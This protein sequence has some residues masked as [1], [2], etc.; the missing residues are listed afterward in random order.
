MNVEILIHGVPDGQ[1]Y[2]GIAEER[3]YAELFYD[4]SAESIKFVVEPK[5]TGNNAFVYYT[6]LRYKGIVGYGGRP[7]SYFGITLRIDKY[8]LDVVHVYNMLD[9][10]FKKHVIGVLLSPLGESYKYVVP[11]FA[12][13]KAE[14]DQ[15]QQGLA[16]LI[17]GTCVWS[18]FVDVDAN[19]IHPDAATASCNIADITENNMSAALKKYSKVILSP[20]YKLNLAKEYEKKIQEAEG[21]GGGMVAEKDKKIAE[22]DGVISSLNSTINSHQAKIETL[23]AEVKRKD[24]EILQIKTRNNLS[25]M[26]SG[27]KEPINS[28]AEYFNVHDSQKNPP[29]PSFGLKNFIIGVVSCVLSLIV[30][31]LLLF[32]KPQKGTVDTKPLENQIAEL[33]N[34]NSQ[35]AKEIELRDNTIADLRTQLAQK[36][37]VQQPSTP[38][39][40]STVV[41][42]KL[43][44]DIDPYKKNELL[45]C[46][47]TYTIK[48]Q[49][50]D[51]AKADYMGNGLW[52]IKNAEIT[53]GKNT[54]S[55]IVI[56]PTGNGSVEIKYQSENCTCSPRIFQ[57]KQQSA[58]ISFE[59]IISPNDSQVEVGKEYTFSV[60]GYEGNGKWSF[61]GF[62]PQIGKITDK[63]I[64]VKAKK[65]GKDAAT[66]SY[67]SD[68][69]TK[70]SRTYE[71]K[72]DESI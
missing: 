47:K 43:R 32:T 33:T 2:Y 13:K 10:V 40:P 15:L 9:M 28:L 59:I 34:T 57:V 5:K 69:G 19:F 53:K 35:L 67:T 27:I 66:V 8:Y 11:N 58:A 4:N 48:V 7:G 14:I 45:D 3:T 70:E 24:N 26:I 56:K 37:E 49:E 64:V 60:S 52:T 1:D 54:D 68:A 21:K 16:Q 62:E 30:I 36:P 39:P 41:V 63:T 31:A 65:N 12:S 38:T 71:Y 17:Q 44:I 61:D 46:D 50:E 29:R 6:Y 23:Q 20:D 25:Q 42:K 55:K 72:A 51:G 22:K 18:K